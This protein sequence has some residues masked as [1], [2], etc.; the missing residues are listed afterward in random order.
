MRA[1]VLEIVEGRLTGRLLPQSWG[2]C[3]DG[4]G[5]RK[6]LLETCAEMGID[7][8]HAITV[9]DG[10]NDLPMTRTSG[11]SVAFHGKPVLRAEAHVTIDEGGLDRLLELFEQV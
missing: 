6:K 4:E 9:G 11:L 3:F 10:A 2:T 7:T 8:A 1:N 5:K